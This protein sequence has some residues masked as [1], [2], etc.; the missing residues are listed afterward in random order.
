M[1]WM[2]KDDRAVFLQVCQANSF[3]AAAERV[4]LT[5]SAVAKTIARLEARLGIVLFQRTTRRLLLTRDGAAYQAACTEALGTLG[6]IEASLT[7]RQQCPAGEVRLS[8]PPLLGAKILAPYLFALCETWPLLEL[9]ITLTT[10]KVDLFETRTDLAIRIGEL[11]TLSQVMTRRLGLQRVGL[12]GSPAYF[13]TH[14]KPQTLLDLSAHRILQGRQ[15]EPALLIEDTKGQVTPFTPQSQLHLDGAELTLAAIERGLGLGI[16][17]L[18]Q[19]RPLCQQG[20]L[21]EVMGEK[22]GGHRTIQA[23]WPQGPH[24]AMDPSATLSPSVRVCLEAITTALK[25]TL[26]PC[27]N[28]SRA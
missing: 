1:S 15:G 14:E 2:S 20:Q 21:I 28:P 23:L 7:A 24:A 26:S 3:A 13:Q 17:P 22:I 4:G 27:E 10:Q 12:F 19:A 25:T 16:L 9:H 5:A 8:L 18:W 11:E 6:S